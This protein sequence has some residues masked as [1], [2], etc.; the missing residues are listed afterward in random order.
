[1]LSDSAISTSKEREPTAFPSLRT[2]ILVP[3]GIVVTAT[4]TLRL[5]AEMGGFMP[6]WLASSI[7]LAALL[8]N[9]PRTWPF[10]SSLGAAALLAAYVLDGINFVNCLMYTVVMGS[11][12][13]LVALGLR[14]FAPQQSWY[15]SGRWIACFILLSCLVC[16]LSGA[17]GAGYVA[18]FYEAPFLY[19]W[20]DWMISDT[21]GLLIGTPFLLI[22]TESAFRSRITAWKVAETAGWTLIVA[23]ISYLAFTSTLPI[24]FLVFPFLA[25]TALRGGLPGATAACITFVGMAMWLMVQKIGPI[26]DES[27]HP[28]MRSFIYQ[29]YFL[30]SLLSTLPFAVMITLREMFTE[31]L[32]EQSEIND[33]ALSNMTQ[34]LAMFD[35]ERR[36]IIANQRYAELYQLPEEALTPGTPLSALFH[37][38]VKAGTYWGERENYVAAA[39]READVLDV[40]REVEL[41][42]GRTI[43]VYRTRLGDGGWLETHED[44]TQRKQA[45]SRIK[46]M[47]SELLHVSRVSAMGTMGSTLAHELNQPLA[48]VANYIGGTRELLKS[49]TDLKAERVDSALAAAEAGAL[50]AGQIVKRLRDLVSRGVVAVAKEDL[51]KLIADAKVLGLVD[52]SAQGITHKVVVE[53]DARWVQAD[54]IQVEQVL[55]NLMRNGIHAMQHAPR[56]EI[57]ISA[58]AVSDDFVEVC[59]ADTGPGVP[60]EVLDK[61]FSPFDSKKEEGLGIGLSICRTI[62]EAHGGRITVSNRETGGAS[63]CFT[64]P[65]WQD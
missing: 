20:R 19:M 18:Y 60:D 25:F 34:G 56:R 55:I 8:R 22:W 16:T 32:R 44:V 33:A 35:A 63:F 23:G 15:L 2:I 41:Y 26:A 40:H 30:T 43:D 17:L 52:A 64:L 65:K 42:D 45:E 48:T 37:Y 39:L 14:R 47:Q 57:T 5:G 13:V 59:V 9:H 29:L 28:F 21:L 61:L 58:R 51:T 27:L 1:M 36:M 11:E 10:L 12:A 62:V 31:K 3:L 7:L 50:R 38:R 54:R 46:Q 24:F 6:L 49:G 53:P 4:F